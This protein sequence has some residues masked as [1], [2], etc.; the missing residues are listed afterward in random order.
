[1][2]FQ[3][4]LVPLDGS[5]FAEAAL[6]FAVR[7]ARSAKARLH[8]VTAHEPAPALVG[9][10]D[11]F[12]P[13]T[14]DEEARQK[15]QEYLAV[16]TGE[17]IEEGTT[18]VDFREI[19]GPGGPAIGEEV[20]R[21]NA[22]LVVMSTHGRGAMG[23][24]W[25]GSVADYLVRH[26]EIPVLL[27]R[28]RTGETAPPRDLRSILVPIDL[29]KES[30]AVFDAVC[31][32]ACLVTDSHVTLIHVVEPILGIVN[33]TLPYPTVLDPGIMEQHRSGAQ[34][35]LDGLADRLREHGASVSTRVVPA[36]SAGAGL[37][38]Q[39]ETRRFDL[40][41]L[42]THGRGGLKRFLLGSVADQVIRGAT[43]PVLVVRPAASSA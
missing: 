32:L 33:P 27:V 10:G 5:R 28:P 20:A 23:R 14:F 36:T 17:L 19:E 35:N 1:M 16:T 39:L 4:I 42:T 38:E 9:M 22:D 26:L 30:E 40:I 15:E 7:L 29:S 31:K 43:K 21:L 37:L 8:L 34:R 11:S 2:S 13:P 24:L 12:P 6:P 3:D 18:P 41:A 25:L